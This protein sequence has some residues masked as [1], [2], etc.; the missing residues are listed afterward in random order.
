M[1]RVCVRRAVCDGRSWLGGGGAHA[2]SPQSASQY[3]ESSTS[4]LNETSSFVS[5]WELHESPSVSIS[6]THDG[7]AAGS[8]SRHSRRRHNPQ[9]RPSVRR[10]RAIRTR[11][12]PRRAAPHRAACVCK[13][14]GSCWQPAAQNGT[15]CRPSVRLVQL[16]AKAKTIPATGCDI[17]EIYYF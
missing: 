1:Q 3:R 10:R 11:T 14:L 4:T 16:T 12:A 7:S 6:M 13:G 15:P 9:L 8:A 17:F 2:L 5:R